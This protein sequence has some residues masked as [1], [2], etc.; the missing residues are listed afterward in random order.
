M[1]TLKLYRNIQV[2]IALSLLG[3]FFSGSVFAAEVDVTL[4]RNIVQ[5]DESFTAVFSASSK[6]DDDPDFSP[7]QKD[8]RT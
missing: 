5:M 8:F 1:V 6:V 2:I 3:M 4:D 7:L